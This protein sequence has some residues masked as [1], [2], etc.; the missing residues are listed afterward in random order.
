M[1]KEMMTDVISGRFTGDKLNLP[2]PKEKD[3]TDPA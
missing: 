3:N 1:F 2:E